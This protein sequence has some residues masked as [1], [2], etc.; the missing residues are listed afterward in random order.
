MF[1]DLNVNHILYSEEE[2]AFKT[3]KQKEI[4]WVLHAALCDYKIT[5]KFNFSYSDKIFFRIYNLDLG[6]ENS[7]YY[8][9]ICTRFVQVMNL[10]VRV[11]FLK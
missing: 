6:F 7:V 4:N 8:Q 1:L 3:T 2:K 10:Q 11:R 9:S 5:R